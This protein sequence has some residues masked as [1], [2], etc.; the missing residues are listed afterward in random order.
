M[1][2]LFVLE[3]VGYWGDRNYLIIV[4][5][6]SGIGLFDVVYIVIIDG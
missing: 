1:C 4:E 3:G 6:V 5:V 2:L